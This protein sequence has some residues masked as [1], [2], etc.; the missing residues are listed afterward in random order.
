MFLFCFWQRQPA[1]FE[2]GMKLEAVDQRNP[3][4]IRV[5]S[6]SELI[7]HRVKLHF[8]G[9]TDIYD[10]LLDDD[11]PDI[12]TVGWCNKTGHPLVPPIRPSQL[13]LSPG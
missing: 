8:D 9:W 5:A 11:S 7:G 2:V 6:V 4:L 3:S 12:H 10:F 1:G 13:V